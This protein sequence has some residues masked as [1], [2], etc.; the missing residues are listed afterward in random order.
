MLLQITGGNGHDR[1]ALIWL[2]IHKIN[3]WIQ[4]PIFFEV[5]YC[6]CG[7]DYPAIDVCHCFCSISNEYRYSSMESVKSYHRALVAGYKRFPSWRGTRFW[8]H[9]ISIRHP[10]TVVASVLT[11]RPWSIPIKTDWHDHRPQVH[12]D[13]NSRIRIHYCAADTG[14]WRTD[15]ILNEAKIWT[16]YPGSWL[17]ANYVWLAFMCWSVILNTC[18]IYQCRCTIL[19]EYIAKGLGKGVHLTLYLE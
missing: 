12:D 13:Q 9:D 18:H 5:I 15:I 7:L 3:Q 4:L 11:I 8:T 19:I 16:W 6:F 10:P 14:H 17:N 2:Y 1:L